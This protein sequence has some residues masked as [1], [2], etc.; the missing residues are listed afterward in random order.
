MFA[1][2]AALAL[3]ATLPWCAGCTA[4][5][6]SDECRAVAQ[7]TNPVLSDIDHDRTVVKG[8]TYRIIAAKYEALAVTLGQVKIRTKHVAEAVNDYQRVLNEAARDARN[9]AD[10]LDGKDEARLLIARASA[11]RTV[12]HEASALSRLDLACHVGR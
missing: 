4:L 8:P 12:R 5:D 7:L 11:A 10:A 2:T 1:R 3:F 6:K 9:F